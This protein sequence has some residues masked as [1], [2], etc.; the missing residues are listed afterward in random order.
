[1]S[2]WYQKKGVFDLKAEDVREKFQLPLYPKQKIKAKTSQT[3]TMATKTV[4]S[5]RGR[6]EARTSTKSLVDSSD[7]LDGPKG[8]M[9][10][11]PVTKRNYHLPLQVLE[12]TEEDGTL[13]ES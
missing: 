12:Y 1:M 6:K 8:R 2:R 9:G 7:K 10:T 11:P 3:V 13:L 4:A 5:P